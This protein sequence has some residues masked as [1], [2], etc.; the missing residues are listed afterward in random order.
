MNPLFDVICAAL[1]KHD[2]KKITEVFEHIKLICTD[3]PS[4]HIDE[5]DITKVLKLTKARQLV[6]ALEKE[7]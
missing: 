3:A 7:G 2:D 5:Q 6:A 1:P 4:R